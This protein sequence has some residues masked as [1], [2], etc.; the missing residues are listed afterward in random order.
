VAALALRPWLSLRRPCGGPGPRSPPT[1]PS[2]RC[3]TASISPILQRHHAGSASS[4]TAGAT[5]AT[6]AAAPWRCGAGPAGRRRTGLWTSGRR[7]A[8]GGSTWAA[9]SSSPTSRWRSRPPSSCWRGARPGSRRCW[10]RSLRRSWRGTRPGL[11]DAVQPERALCGPPRR[12]GLRGPRRPALGAAPRAR[13]RPRELHP[14][15]APYGNFLGP[16]KYS[17]WKFPVQR[18]FWAQV[19]FSGGRVAS[20]GVA[21]PLQL[22]RG[23]VPPLRR[24]GRRGQ[25]R[26][27][28]NAPPCTPAALR[29]IAGVVVCGGQCWPLGCLLECDI[30]PQKVY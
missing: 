13:K 25:P 10:P 4:S 18:I 1:Q 22:R 24:A 11:R 21:A 16:K 5:R 6:P 3:P 19:T 7:R 9:A 14:G 8:R 27:G 17:L 15:A 20:A 12:R 23:R 28:L 26:P 2:G 29:P 30:R